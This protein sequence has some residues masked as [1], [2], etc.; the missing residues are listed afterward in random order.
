M[1]EPEHGPRQPH[2]ACEPAVCSR[3]EPHNVTAGRENRD[4]PINP[5]L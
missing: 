4:E 3:P 1:A 2:H 5:S